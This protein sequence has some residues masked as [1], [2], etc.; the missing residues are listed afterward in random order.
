[1]SH[2][3]SPINIGRTWSRHSVVTRDPRIFYWDQRP[4]VMPDGDFLAVY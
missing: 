1:M 3:S 4:Q 2:L